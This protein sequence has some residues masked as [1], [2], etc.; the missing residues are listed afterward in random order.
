M[1]D[2]DA[3]TRIR[4]YEDILRHLG[5][6]PEELVKQELKK[7]ADTESV[8]SISGVPEP[9][10]PTQKRRS[11][12]PAESGILVS[13]DGRSRYLENG[14]WTSLKGEFRE[15]K[16]ILDESSDDEPTES[17]DRISPD[18]LTTDSSGLL[19]G[20][21]A[22]SARL[23]PLHPEPVQTFKLWQSYLNNINPLVKVFHAPTVQ[24]IISDA[25]GS[26][27][28]LPRDVEA[29]MFG[30]YCIATESLSDGECI[31]ILGKSKSVVIHRFRLGA[32]Q[33]L[34]NTS[35]L[36]TSNLMVLQAFTLFVVRCSIVPSSATLRR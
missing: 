21:Q 30:I 36:K 19:F 12:L 25:C 29:L 20:S 15:S 11:H 5:V 10:K 35:L 18:E 34:V 14:I 4:I 16:E 27:D 1:R 3:T 26:M 13:E 8:L 17:H 7:L 2:V 6:D 28:D 32:Q 9:H 33:A 24:Q 23:R 22:S 31:A